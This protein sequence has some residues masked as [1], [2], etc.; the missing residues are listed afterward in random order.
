MR[1]DLRLAPLTEL[2]ALDDASFRERFAGTPVKRTGRDRF[3]RNVLCA[4]GNSRN[5]AL[6]AAA[7]ARLEDNSPQV[8]GM[9]VWAL[10]QLLDANAFAALK[11]ARAAQESDMVVREEWDA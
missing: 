9:A 5:A 2:A 11:S 1:D 4:I 3:V 7:E 6:A 10:R 8:R